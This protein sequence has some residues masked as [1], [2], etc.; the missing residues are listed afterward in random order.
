MAWIDSL[1]SISA[2]SATTFAPVVAAIFLAA[3][4]FG[5]L[6]ATSSAPGCRAIFFVWTEPIKP[7]PTTATLS[8]YL[9]LLIFV[10]KPPR[11]ASM[12][13]PPRRSAS[14]FLQ[15]LP[16]SP[17]PLR[18]ENRAQLL[19]MLFRPPWPKEHL[20]LLYTDWQRLQRILPGA[21]VQRASKNRIDPVFI[22][23]LFRLGHRYV[24]LV[25]SV[26]GNLQFLC[27]SQ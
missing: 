24:I 10:F 15:R 18:P 22:P 6:T 21:R 2:I 23:P 26:G 12:R 25:N 1:L 17:R 3:S 14:R 7:V 9:S 4:M 11:P 5:S 27:G 20:R 8:I 19:G 16:Q 13:P